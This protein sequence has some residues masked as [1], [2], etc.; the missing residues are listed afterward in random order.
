[1]V[2][3]LYFVSFPLKR[4]GA[5]APPRKRA[6]AVAGFQSGSKAT[7]AHLDRRRGGE[8]LRHAAASGRRPRCCDGA[9]RGGFSLDAAVL[10][11]ATE[12][13]HNTV[14]G[15]PAALVLFREQIFG[16]TVLL[17]VPICIALHWN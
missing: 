16:S 3:K 6:S 4:D 8:S 13:G 15:S 14:A 2:K 11:E 7:V 10:I 9:T 5:A 1:M 12:G 17:I